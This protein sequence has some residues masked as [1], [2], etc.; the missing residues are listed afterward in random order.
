MKK[1]Q[2][3]LF[4]DKDDSTILKSLIFYFLFYQY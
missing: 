2:L 1:N 4:H 3:S